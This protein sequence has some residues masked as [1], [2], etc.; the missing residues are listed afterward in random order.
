MFLG[1][2]SLLIHLLYKLIGGNINRRKYFGL[3][4]LA[5]F[6]ELVILMIQIATEENSIRMGM[7]DSLISLG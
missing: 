1:S 2:S 3:L 5:D 7:D 4:I 6:A